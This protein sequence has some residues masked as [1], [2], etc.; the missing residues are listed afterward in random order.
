[1]SKEKE[2]LESLLGA[3]NEEVPPEP[4]TPFGQQLQAAMGS[5]VAYM[6]AEG[7]IE[8]EDDAVESL[9]AELTSVGLEAHSP[10]Q[11]MKRMSRTLLQSDHVEEVFG[12][13]DDISAAVKRFLEPE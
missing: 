5:A 11:M 2:L 7:V 13:D 10:R 6:R 3:L 1:M 12:S 9:V 8:V 4:D